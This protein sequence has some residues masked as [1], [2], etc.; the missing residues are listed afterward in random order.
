MGE[1]RKEAREKGER[2]GRE[3]VE[4]EE[5]RFHRMTENFVM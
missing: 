2:W 5:E 4:R 1:R 3:K